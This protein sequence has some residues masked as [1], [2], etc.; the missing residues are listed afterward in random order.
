MRTDAFISE[1]VS[2][3]LIAYTET[4]H[5]PNIGVIPFGWPQNAG[6]G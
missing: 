3:K 2:I 4:S 6:R 1:G 5:I